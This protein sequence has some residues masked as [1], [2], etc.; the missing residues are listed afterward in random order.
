MKQKKKKNRWRRK[1]TSLHSL[2]PVRSESDSNKS[3]MI[4]WPVVTR[5]SVSPKRYSLIIVIRGASA[6]SVFGRALGVLRIII[7]NVITAQR[8]T[9]N[10]IAYRGWWWA[11][12]RSLSLSS[13]T[14]SAHIFPVTIRRR[15]SRQQYAT[16]ENVCEIVL[17]HY[18]IIRARVYKIRR[19][20]SRWVVAATLDR[21][22]TG[23]DR[24][25]YFFFF[26]RSY[27]VMI[28]SERRK[29]SENWVSFQS[30]NYVLICE[31]KYHDIA[32]KYESPLVSERY[33]NYSRAYVRRLIRAYTGIEK[34]IK[35]D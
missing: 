20:A 33:Y 34:M 16:R 10:L 11:F 5:W 22:R 17:R 23:N 18:R 35:R 29:S 25:I 4:D 31:R 30:E 15:S 9:K 6:R 8:S 21:M 13:H 28:S 32:S 7:Y 27:V 26:L 2:N 3:L 12:W 19:L 24:F 14:C 1:T